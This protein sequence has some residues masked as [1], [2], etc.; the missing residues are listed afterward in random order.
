MNSEFVVE[1]AS[2]D[3]QAGRQIDSLLE[4]NRLFTAWTENVYHRRVH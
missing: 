4:M 3:G 2:G 1:I